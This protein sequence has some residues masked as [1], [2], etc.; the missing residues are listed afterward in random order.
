[1]GSGGNVG[2]RSMSQRLSSEYGLSVHKETVRHLLQIVDPEGVAQRSRHRLQRRQYRARGPNFIWHIDGYDKL[3]PFGFCIHG[4]IDGYSRRLMWL[5]VGPSNNNPSIV[6][7]YFVECVRQVGGTPRI[8]RVDCGTEN[9]NTAAIQRFLRANS[10]D[11]FAGEKSFIYGKSVSNQ[12]IEAWWGILRKS[13]SDWWINYFKD[14]RNS[15]LYDDSDHLHVECLKF[16]YY[17][18]LKEELHKTARL[19]NLHKIRPS[20]N[21]ESPAGRPDVLYHLPEVSG[22]RNYSIEV[23]D[24]DLHIA[25]GMCCSVSPDADCDPR[26]R[27]WQALLWQKKTF[28]CQTPTKKQGNCTY[29]PWQVF[30]RPLHKYE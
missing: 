8:I 25:E 23:D 20:S 26:L 7:Q 15:G 13:C 1:M 2:Y 4:A 22:T 14:M 30:R 9:V 28:T 12:R 19:W 18:V 29:E 27:N 11:S 3:K 21:E 6:A 16:G 5:E 24:D 17:P 10:D